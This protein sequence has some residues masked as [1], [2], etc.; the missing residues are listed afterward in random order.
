[1]KSLIKTYW[2]RDMV[3]DDAIHYLPKVLTDGAE[4]SIKMQMLNIA[5]KLSAAQGEKACNWNYINAI[6]DG[7]EKR[8]I[9][10]PEE[11]SAYE[12]KRKGGAR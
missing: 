4:D 3:F 5:L 11:W 7:W 9:T 6:Y 12:Q 8:G 10:T 2:Q 1:M